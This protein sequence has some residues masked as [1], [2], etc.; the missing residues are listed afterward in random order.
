MTKP[1]TVVAI[2]AAYN[3]ADIIGEVVAALVEDG[4]RVYFIDHG[5]TDDTVA[6]V[7]PFRDRG[8]IG[9]ETFVAGGAPVGDHVFAWRSLLERKEELAS[10]LDADWFIH[11]DADEFR[12]SP[13]EGETLLDGIARVDAAGYNAID[14][15]VF[16]F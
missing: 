14:F 3:E 11:H 7:E 9:I 15:H 10:Q 1:L 4:I 5:S 2:V 8:V 6:R 13:W 12:E 16:D